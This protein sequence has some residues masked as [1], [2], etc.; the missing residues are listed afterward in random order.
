[1][2][3][4]IWKNM[5][6][7][8]MVIFPHIGCCF[9][10]VCS[11]TLLWGSH[12]L[13]IYPLPRKKNFF[14]TCHNPLRVCRLEISARIILNSA[15]TVGCLT[16]ILAALSNVFRKASLSLMKEQ[17]CT[18]DWQSL[19][20]PMSSRISYHFGHTGERL[21]PGLTR[22][23]CILRALFLTVTSLWPHKG[24]KSIRPDGKW[25]WFLT[26]PKT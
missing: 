12:W 20:R 15:L 3:Y 23:D 8:R 26:R 7:S 24:G 18:I 17:F 19:L 16:L 22:K 4:L 6:A 11:H 14:I 1:M 5:S 21:I 10:S 25:S 2:L 13:L 9:F